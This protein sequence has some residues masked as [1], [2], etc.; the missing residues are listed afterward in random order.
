MP[1]KKENHSSTSVMR[2]KSGAAVSHCMTGQVVISASNVMP[3][4]T[5]RRPI[6][7]EIA[8]PMGNQIKLDTPTN[9]VTIKLSRALRLSTVLP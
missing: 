7:S 3:I 5:A 9:M 1:K 8:P 4:N 6:R 2:V